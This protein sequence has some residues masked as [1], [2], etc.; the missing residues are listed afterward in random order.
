MSFLTPQP[1]PT[2]AARRIRMVGIFALRIV[3]MLL[4]KM[5]LLDVASATV[6]CA[7]AIAGRKGCVSE[8]MM[9]FMVLFFFD[10]KS[11]LLSFYHHQYES[12]KYQTIARNVPKNIALAI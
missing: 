6:Y 3:P 8:K 10:K 12:N 2:R 7:C 11:T 1:R 9:L 5:S 4:M